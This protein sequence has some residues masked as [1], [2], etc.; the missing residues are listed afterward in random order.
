MPVEA[1]KKW[2]EAILK[3]QRIGEAQ[4][5]QG[6]NLFQEYLLRVDGTIETSTSST[7]LN[8]EYSSVE[9]QPLSEVIEAFAVGAG[10]EEDLLAHSPAFPDGSYHSSGSENLSIL[11]H[12]NMVDNMTGVG[13][14]LG[15]V[16][17]GCLKATANAQRSSKFII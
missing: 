8:T 1:R 3:A 13:A 16:T 11:R 12:V 15:T 7:D 9:C 10:A 4:Q 14:T 17:Y 5:C 6:R 2:I